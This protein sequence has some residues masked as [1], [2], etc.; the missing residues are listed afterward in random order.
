MSADE[1]TVDPMF[2]FNADL[3]DHSNQHTA[4][5]VIECGDDIF[6]SDAFWRVE[7]PDG[8]VVRGRDGT[9]PF[10]LGDMPANARTLRVGTTG[11]GEV[12]EDNGAAIDRALATHNVTVPAAS[13]RDGCACSSSG[14]GA[15]GFALVALVLAA[16]WRRK[17]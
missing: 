1:M 15:T 9:W 2:D 11:S 7:L 16:L 14:G 10:A 17:R 4:E 6:F 8:R 12:V 13:D 3:P 5:R